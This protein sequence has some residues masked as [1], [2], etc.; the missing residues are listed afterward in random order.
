[1]EKI[2]LNQTEDDISNSKAC[3]IEKFSNGIE[4]DS[5]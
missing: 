4:L 3:E 5:E 1:M 2:G